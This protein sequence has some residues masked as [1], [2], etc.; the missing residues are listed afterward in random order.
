MLQ[1]MPSAQPTKVDL[2]QGITPSLPRT[3][4]VS[5]AVFSGAPAISDHQCAL[6]PPSQ[7]GSV[8]TTRGHAFRARQRV[9]DQL[10]GEPLSSA[11]PDPTG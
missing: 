7:T 9:A 1:Q 4:T 5:P 11:A 8:R 2:I 6:V 3:L 10:A